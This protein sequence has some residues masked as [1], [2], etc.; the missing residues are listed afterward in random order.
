MF[1]TGGIVLCGG[2]SNRHGPSEGL[3]AVR[4]RD[5]A[6][7]AWY[8]GYDQPSSQSSWWRHRTRTCRRFP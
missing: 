3:A 7:R 4:R 8:G 1:R 5:D 2:Q 6:A